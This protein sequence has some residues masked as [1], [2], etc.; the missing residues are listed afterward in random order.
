[1]KYYALLRRDEC[2]STFWISRQLHFLS[3][4]VQQYRL[5]NI[6]A[7]NFK[8]PLPLTHASSKSVV[9]Q[10]YMTMTQCSLTFFVEI[11]DLQ[12][13]NTKFLSTY[14]LEVSHF[15]TFNVLVQRILDYHNDDSIQKN[16]SLI[17]FILDNCNGKINQW[18]FCNECGNWIYM[19]LIN[20]CLSSESKVK[21]LCSSP[22]STFFEDLL[23]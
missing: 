5:Q 8:F 9:K 10:S 19:T 18:Y 17:K 2:I 11:D 1:M 7:P 20:D 21:L 15:V 12:I 3:D 16:V 22:Q 14:I 13:G 4:P 6:M 23:L